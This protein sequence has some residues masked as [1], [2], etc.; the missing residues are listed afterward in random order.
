MPYEF[1]AELWLYQGHAAWHFVTVA[2]AVSD[3]IEARSAGRRRGFGSVRVRATIGA[4]TWETS[5]FPD[6]TRR[7]FLLPVKRRV[8]DLEGI[9]AGDRVRT[10]LELLDP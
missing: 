4:T 10:T 2:A 7:A 3:A 8:R 9:T 1:D 5:V 6:S